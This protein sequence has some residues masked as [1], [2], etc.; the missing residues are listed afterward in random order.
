MI[1][2]FFS[3]L[4]C[5]AVSTFTTHAP[6]EASVNVIQNSRLSQDPLEIEFTFTNTKSGVK[7]KCHL[8]QSGANR[9]CVTETESGAKEISVILSDRV[10]HYGPAT[11][12]DVI[13]LDKSVADNWVKLCFDP[14]TI[15]L[16]TTT[17]FD[18]TVSNLLTEGVSKYETISIE[19]IRD[20]PI[21]RVRVHRESL[22]LDYDIHEPTSRLYRKQT[23]LSN[24]STLLSELSLEYNNT[25]DSW[26]P[27]KIVC[28]DTLNNRGWEMS[29]IGFAKSVL[30]EPFSLRS[31][32]IPIG[33][34]VVDYIEKRRIGYWNGKNIVE[35]FP[36]DD[37]RGMK[38]AESSSLVRLPTLI[39][40]S[41]GVIAIVVSWLYFRRRN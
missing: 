14:R 30:E 36:Y 32:E 7:T 1:T 23:Y 8:L 18:L 3:F 11:N 31:M 10:W 25:D 34:A 28:V 17:A 4:F 40:L 27:S 16:S 19:T 6:A 33:T 20:I 2:Y 21:T 12:A 38:T 22:W 9:R 13:Q 26:L 35:D 29:D 41:I 5:V 15:G 24:N 37:V 39:L